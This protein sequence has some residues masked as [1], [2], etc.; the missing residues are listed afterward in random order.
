MSFL[1]VPVDGKTL[2]WPRRVANAIKQL[3]SIIGVRET[4]PFQMLDA[5]PADPVEGQVYYSRTDHMARVWDGST[6]QDMW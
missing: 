4:L 3:Q 1:P 6:W 5:V 2:D